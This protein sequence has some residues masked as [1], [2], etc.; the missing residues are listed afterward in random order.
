MKDNRNQ[1][2]NLA[3]QRVRLLY[4]S[5]Y[6]QAMKIAEV[7]NA[8]NAATD[9]NF[10]F[11]ANPGAERKLR[12]ILEEL[13]IKLDN[14]ITNGKQTLAKD[15]VKV[16]EANVL[17]KV[18]GSQ[19]PIAER[20]IQAATQTTR[21]AQALGTEIANEKRGGVQL[22]PKV[23]KT[24]ETSRKE[25]EIIIQ[26]N[27]IEGKG[28]DVAS[29]E[30]RQYLKDTN[31]LFRRVK[32]KTTG[33]YKLSKAAQQY[34]PGQGKYR[35][36][37]MNA[38]RLTVTEMNMA[39]QAAESAAYASNPL[40]AGYE[41]RLSNNHTVKDPSKKGGVKPLHDICD[42]LQGK[43]PATFKFTGWHPHCR[44]T[45][46][47][48]LISAEERKK[49]A[50]ARAEGK[51]Y[52]PKGVITDVPDN[53]KQWVAANQDRIADAKTLPFFLQDNGEMTKGGY[54]ISE[55]PE[56]ASEETTTA[57]QATPAAQEPL[58]FD[59]IR[60]TQSRLS[61]EQIQAFV[62]T[63]DEIN[64]RTIFR[65]EDGEYSQK[66]QRLHNRIVNECTKDITAHSDT[67]FMLGGAPA[68]G[69]STLVESGMLK[70]PEGALVVDSDTIKTMIPEYKTMQ[71]SGKQNLV[72]AAADFVHAESSDINKEVQ[73][74]A[75]KKNLAVVV[76]GVNDGTFDE[77]AERVATIKKQTGGK[78]IRADYV[79]LDTDLSLKL[80]E[81]RAQRTGRFVPA[82]VIKD[83]NRDIARLFPQLLEKP[84]FDELYLWDTNEN[85]NPRLIL[86]MVGGK[87]T[88]QSKE[89][90]G[91]FLR[92]AL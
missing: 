65:D 90:Y 3:E 50:Q 16:A 30:V 83:Y 58:D 26:N 59:Y 43:Y 74:E 75:Y 73:A 62:E 47:P 19:K 8:L 2:M 22:S 82:K 45:M 20:L 31:R 84:V 86:K 44:C 61:E 41:I 89:L 6:D 63:G 23:W 15:G 40:I 55:F 1:L 72:R 28:A 67:V 92:K 14:L 12:K 17:A 70:H 5:A 13:G 53:Y 57:Q 34:H 68:N 46:I 21:V 66:R 37:Y 7:R 87:L 25:L 77:V 71:E 35:S 88:I 29:R 56:P 10:T 81:A 9:E 33:E 76:D 80:A 27:I 36:S 49:L 32:D 51:D 38:R 78:P 18:A 91:R 48:I 54:V 11:K 79:T 64:T 4:T 60:E 24:V 39:T 69:K 42:E 52:Q 85:G